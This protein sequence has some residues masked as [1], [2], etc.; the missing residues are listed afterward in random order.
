MAFAHA[1]WIV[2]TS[3]CFMG[4]DGGY[5]SSASASLPRALSFLARWRTLTSCCLRLAALPRKKPRIGVHTQHSPCSS[6]H[7]VLPDQRRRD[8]LPIA[9]PTGKRTPARTTVR[10]KELQ[11][12][13]IPTFLSICSGLKPCKMGFFLSST[14]HHHTQSSEH[15]KKPQ[16]TNGRAPRGFQSESAHSRGGCR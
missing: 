3:W 13:P 14:P 4:G 2:S 9:S 5:V 12:T 16:Q 6:I 1:S 10:T 8:E 15:K 7:F 11:K